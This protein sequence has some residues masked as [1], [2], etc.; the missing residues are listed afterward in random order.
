MAKPRP[1]P[2]PRPARPRASGHVVIDDVAR[3]AGVST[4]TISRYF[5]APDKVSP[6]TAARIRGVIRSTGYVPNLVAGSL[7]SNRSRIVAILVPTIANPVHAAPVQGLADA[8]RNEGYQVLVG[9]TGY[10]AAVELR[11]VETF[12]GRR[13]DGIVITGAPLD[14]RTVDLLV[15]TRTPTVQLWELEP[16][17][18]DLAV[19]FSNAAV[20][21]AM[22]RHLI[23]RGYRRTAVVAHAAPGDTRS[24]AR[25]AG[26]EGV[27]RRARLAAPR[28]I[29][30]EQP[31][32]VGA[33]PQLLARIRALRPRV[34]AVFCVSDLVAIGLILACQRAGVAVPGRLAIAG[35]GDNDLAAL[36]TP[37]LSTVHIPRYELGHTAGRMLLDRFA[38]REPE[39]RVIDVGFELRVREST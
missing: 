4:Q 13:V 15:R 5:R 31:T 29:D 14:P 26:F 37:S 32:A 30:L 35:V 39:P 11:L 9:T 6:T 16:A 23:E 27:L 33:T 28:R 21:A 24:A 20:G 1:S 7:A 22:A 36:V 8:I 2:P 10:S 34:E 3:M 38:G 12:L 17:P 19:G 18:V 25:V